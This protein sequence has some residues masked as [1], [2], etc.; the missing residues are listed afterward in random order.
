MCAC[1]CMALLGMA[2]VKGL[3]FG[4]SVCGPQMVPAMEK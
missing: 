3:L 4:G 2:M 1:V